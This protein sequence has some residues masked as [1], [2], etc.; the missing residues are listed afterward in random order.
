MLGKLKLT[1]ILAIILCYIGFLIAVYVRIR[2]SDTAF[3]RD[4]G[5]YAYAGLQILNGR[6]P[7][8][9]FYNMKQPG[10]YYSFAAILGLFAKSD[11]AI[12]VGVMVLNLGTAFFIFNIAAKLIQREAAWTASLAFL[13][14]SLGY[15][16][17]GLASNSE[18]FVVFWATFG[19]WAIVE[20]K[21]FGAGILLALSF[22]MKQHAAFFG[23]FAVVYLL[24]NNSFKDFFVKSLKLIA[25]YSVVILGLFGWV[26]QNGFWERYYLLT[27]KY[28]AAYISLDTFAVD[29]I[30]KRVDICEENLLFWIAVLAAF[31]FIFIKF[32][33]KI[34]RFSTNL[35]K[36]RKFD[37]SFKTSL[38]PIFSPEKEPNTEGVILLLFFLFSFAAVFPGFFFRRHYFQLIFPAAALL[39]AYGFQYLNFRIPFTKFS[40]PAVILVAASLFYSI[41]KQKVYYF[42]DSGEEYNRKMYGDNYFNESKFLGL[43]LRDSTQKEDVIGQFGNEPQLWF[44]AQRQAAS[45][46]LYKYPLGEKQPFKELM[47]DMYIQETEKNAPKWFIQSNISDY[48]SDNLPLQNWYDCYVEKYK[49]TGVL[50]ATK[51]TL[52]SILTWNIEKDDTTR[53]E[54]IVVYKRIEN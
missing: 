10:V 28:A 51:D 41:N 9:D 4:E 39:S 24:F 1:E 32:F 48:G 8:A 44:Y 22:L 35:V 14:F 40:F 38:S 23:I 42:K 54:L 26:Y 33:L 45:G 2:M 30:L 16:A 11:V 21:Y 12:R 31:L 34:G 13:L 50:Y 37:F 25:G 20:K 27:F 49:P 19:L 5:E 7:Y 47:T 15:H 29:D 36:N 6:L 46:F 53:K 3:E 17:Q 43:L 18:H 52:N